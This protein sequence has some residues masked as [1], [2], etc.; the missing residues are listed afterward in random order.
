MDPQARIVIPQKFREAMEGGMVLAR[1]LDPCIE[2]YSPVEWEA[3]SSRVKKFSPFDRNGRMLRR[4]TFASAFNAST[5]KQGRIVLP[6]VLR[7]HAGITDEVVMTGQ[8]NYFEIWS[9][10]HWSQQE[11]QAVNLASIAEELEQGG[12]QTSGRGI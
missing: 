11:A 12:S 2:A 7:E 10:E 3:V 1:G 4:L 9:P 6:Q 8:D 5:D